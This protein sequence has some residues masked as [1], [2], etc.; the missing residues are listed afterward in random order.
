MEQKTMQTAGFNRSRVRTMPLFLL[1]TLAAGPGC[2]EPSEDAKS[3]KPTARTDTQGGDTETDSS[4]DSASAGDGTESPEYPGD[5]SARVRALIDSMTLEEKVSQMGDRSPAIPRLNIP[6]YLWW[7]E[8][9]HGVARSGIATVFPQAIALA[10]TFDPEL[11]HT[12]S[13]AI[14]TEARVKNNV[15]NKAL[16]YWSPTV[17]LAR[18]PRWGRNE[19]SYGEDPFLA[20][21]IAVAFV[22]GLQGDDPDYL[23]TVST[24]KHFI[25]NNEEYRR[26]YGSSEVDERNLREFYMPAF[27]SAVTEGGATSVMCAYN[28][29]NGIPSCANEWLLDDVLRNEWGFDGYVVSDCWAIQDIVDGHNF[30]ETELEASEAAITAGTDLNCGDRFQPDLVE[31]VTSGMISEALVDQ[32]VT[33]LFTARFRLG[34]FDPPEAVPYRNIPAEALDSPEHRSLALD[35]AR[36]SMVLLKNE[37]LLPLDP[38]AL[39]SVAVIGPNA[40]RILFGGY[41]GQAADP[42][43]PLMGIRERLLEL[44]T[45]VDFHQGCDTLGTEV[46]DPEGAAKVAAAAEVAVVVLGIDLYLSNEG[47]DRDDLALPAAQEALLEAVTAANPNTVLVLVTGGP[48]AITWADENVPAIL[49]AWYGG[50]SAGTAIA[51][52]LFGDVSPSGRLPQTFYRSVEDLPP[53]DDYDVIEGKRTYMFFDQPVLYPFGHGLGYTRFDYSD[54]TVTPSTV[55]D[56]ETITVSFTVENTGEMAGDEVAQVYVHDVEA[57]VPVAIKQLKGFE[58]LPLDAGERREVA[59][60]IDAADLGTFDEGAGRFVVEPGAFDIL[61]G[62]S[63]EDIRLTGTVTV[64]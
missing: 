62:A 9:L 53:F 40:D 29:L 25:A 28:A 14:S 24:P 52:I 26:H 13:T 11:I 31:A 58:R 21:R 61:V 49:N 43:S 42:K 23:K 38:A 44:G 35:V 16:T 39:D 41:S 55:A 18:D 20:S 12:V 51:E 33:R 48:L 4:R 47:L 6:S 32:A 3:E 17:N 59:V 15:Q 54:L 2:S 63:S 50:Q 22:R 37:G 57:S 34:E 30:V 7:N 8:A 27:R 36:K 5:I 60:T 64:D 1:A 56:N 19:E 45:R 46:N 10:G